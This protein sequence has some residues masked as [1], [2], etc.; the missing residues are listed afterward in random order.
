M[1]INVHDD[2]KLVDIWLTRRERDDQAV[3][4]SLKPLYR[5]YAEKQYTVAVF[6]GGELGLTEETNAL[7]CY[8]RRRIAELEVQREQKKPEALLGMT[9]MM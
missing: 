1:E 3:Q 6:M 8:N 4:E 5:K 7:L 2:K 9:M